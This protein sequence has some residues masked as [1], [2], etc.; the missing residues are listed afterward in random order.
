MRSFFPVLLIALGFFGTSSVAAVPTGYSVKEEVG[1]P[2]GWLKHSRP[3]PDHAIVLRIGLLQPNFHLL[4]KKLYEVSDPDHERYGQHLSKAEVEALVAPHQESIALVNEW[5]GKF[6]VNEDSLVR[7][8]AKD[9]VSL[10]VPV[11]LAEKMLDTVSLKFWLRQLSSS[12]NH[13][14]RPITSGSILKAVITWSAL[15]TTVFPATFMI[16]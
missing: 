7:S 6:G 2:R 10:K 15:Q 14:C 4:E 8:P 5:L 11:S 1:P 9:W 3:P 13:F 16:I 12:S